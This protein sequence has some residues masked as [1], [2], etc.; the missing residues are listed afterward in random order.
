MKR[1]LLLVDLWSQMQ[2]REQTP[3]RLLRLQQGLL[4]RTQKSAWRRQEAPRLPHWLL[5]VLLPH[6]WRHQ[7]SVQLVLRAQ[8]WQHH[9]MR[10]QS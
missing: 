3:L 4:H 2:K 6:C 8:P 1:L 5:P 7:S 10:H 9:W